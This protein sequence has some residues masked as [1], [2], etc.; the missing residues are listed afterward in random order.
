MPLG[1]G[2][3]KSLIENTNQEEGRAVPLNWRGTEIDLPIYKVRY[4]TLRYNH[5]NGRIGPHLREDCV[6]RGVELDEYFNQDFSQESHQIHLRAI[7]TGE[8]S[9]RKLAMDAFRNGERLDYT[10]A[11]IVTHD[12]R[13]I[14]GNQRLSIFSELV[15]ENP[16]EFAHLEYPYIAL[17]PADGQEV[18]YEKIEMKAQENELIT[19]A[20][21]WVQAGISRRTKLEAG[22]FGVSELAGL[23]NLKEKELL[24]SIGLINTVDLYLEFIGASGM[25][26]SEVRGK[27]L[28]Q[29][30]GEIQTGISKLDKKSLTAQERDDIIQRFCHDAFT[31]MNT[32]NIA[33]GMGIGVYGLVRELVS[34]YEDVAKIMV[35]SKTEKKTTKPSRGAGGLRRKQTRQS[36]DDHEPSDETVVIPI[37][38]LPTL[39]EG[40]EGKLLGQAIRDRRTVMEEKADASKQKLYAQNQVPQIV[41]VLTKVED[42]WGDMDTDG[43]EEHLTQAYEIIGR[44]LERGDD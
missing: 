43:L 34:T 16:R 38:P 28:E 3:F 5:R 14:N 31:A 10:K 40:D 35:K 11:L 27:K 39:G 9:Q 37:D 7:L 4:D 21:D 33:D 25:Y 41:T 20:F 15:E 8:E 13:V 6:R 36:K 32:P 18:D 44:L 30:F 2:A 26:Q 22:T 19:S 17:L 24:D 12:G 1:P 23:L 42:G 29:S